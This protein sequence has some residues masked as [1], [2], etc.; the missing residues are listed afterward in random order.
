V[1]DVKIA[2]HPT[3]AAALPV[4]LIPNCAAN[5]HVTVALDGTGSV[6]FE[7]PSP[8]DWPEIILERTRGTARPVNL[9]PLT[10]EDMADWRL[11]E[12]LLLSGSSWR[13]AMPPTSGLP[14]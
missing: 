11:G 1:L 5:R 14:I 9:D 6:E 8:A 4:G 7:S 2:T 12:T 3:H 13:R 10:R